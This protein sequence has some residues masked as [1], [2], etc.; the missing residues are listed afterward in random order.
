MYWKHP[1]RIQT[2]ARLFLDQ[3]SSYDLLEEEKA[4]QATSD[5]LR[6]IWLMLDALGVP[7]QKL[8]IL[9]SRKMLI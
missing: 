2:T 8:F 6:L 5:E 7:K 3:D 9:L 4:N 1:C